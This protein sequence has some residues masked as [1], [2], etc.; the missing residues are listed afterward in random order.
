LYDA[1][2]FW[3]IV[4]TNETRIALVIRTSRRGA[5]TSRDAAIHYKRMTGDKGRIVRRE[6]QDAL[7]DL[8]RLTHPS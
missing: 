1:K 5:E 3:L 6:E 8:G 2:V 7:G 4:P